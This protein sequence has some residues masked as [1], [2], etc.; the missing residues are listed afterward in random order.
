MRDLDFQQA[1][2]LNHQN[3]LLNVYFGTPHAEYKRK[4]ELIFKRNHW[5]IPQTYVRKLST[6]ETH[7]IFDIEK[8]SEIND[9]SK[10]SLK[11][12]QMLYRLFHILTRDFYKPLFLGEIFSNLFPGEYYNP[13]SSAERVAQAIKK[14]RKWFDQNDLPLEVLV[15]NG[16]YSLKASG[17]IALK[18]SKNTKSA[19]ELKSTGFESQIDLLKKKWPYQSFSTAM[20]AKELNISASATRLLLRKALEEKAIY[21]SGAGRNTLYRF[22]K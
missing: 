11:P 2:F 4:I 14:L 15:E 17:P 3:L 1:L 13:D 8:A 5:K 21:C 19:E 7:R 10:E 22:S 9:P 18:I 16:Q 6:E 12:G 20:A